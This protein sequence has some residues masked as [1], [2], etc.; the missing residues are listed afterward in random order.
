MPLLYGVRPHSFRAGLMCAFDCCGESPNWGTFS[1]VSVTP[2]PDAAL[3]PA[4]TRGAAP[5]LGELPL[6][7]LPAVGAG[8]RVAGRRRLQR[9]QCLAR[10]GLVPVVHAE[11]RP[12]LDGGQLAGGAGEELV[13]QPA[14]DAQALQEDAVMGDEGEIRRAVDDFH[15]RITSATARPRKGR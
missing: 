4:G 13:A 6:Q 10:P 7:A 1:G 11:L 5:A 3:R 14:R 8:P 12:A 15:A 9:T 2:C